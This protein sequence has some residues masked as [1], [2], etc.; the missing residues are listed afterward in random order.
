[1]S[2]A[3]LPLPIH[4]RV[5]SFSCIAAP[6]ELLVTDGISLCILKLAILAFLY[7]RSNNVVQVPTEHNIKPFDSF[8]VC[9]FS[10]NKESEF[11]STFKVVGNFSITEV[12]KT[13]F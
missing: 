13:H 6:W 3:P 12:L 8:Q 1:M 5:T 4:V 2:I 7:F 11:L 10:R 9:L